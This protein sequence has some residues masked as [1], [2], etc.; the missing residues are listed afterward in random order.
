MIVR[1]AAVAVLSLTVAGCSQS[2]SSKSPAETQAGSAAEQ[3]GE[4]FEGAA[5]A[6][7]GSLPSTDDLVKWLRAAPS[8]EG[9]AGGLFS[10]KMEWATIV[11]R[12]GV[13][14]ATAV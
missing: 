13:I 11:D 2:S 14:C 7:C 3:S 9:E 4:P 1:Y 12:Q 8:A 10:G 5:A 6:D